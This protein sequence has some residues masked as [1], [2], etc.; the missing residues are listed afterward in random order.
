MASTPFPFLKT[1]LCTLYLF[2]C[3]DTFYKLPLQEQHGCECQLSTLQE[4]LKTIFLK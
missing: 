4:P 3:G 2:Q 1:P